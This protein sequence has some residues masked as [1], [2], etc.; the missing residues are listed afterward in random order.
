MGARRWRRAC[1]TPPWKLRLSLA[2]ARHWQMSHSGLELESGAQ[3]MCSL[4]RRTFHLHCRQLCGTQHRQLCQ[5][6]RAA[7]SDRQ[8]VLEQ[9]GQLRLTCACWLFQPRRRAAQQRAEGGTQPL[10]RAELSCKRSGGP[11]AR[12]RLPT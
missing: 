1:W 11:A 8:G 4:P 3:C 7:G 5:Q 2:S 10:A 6:W 12:A 9:R